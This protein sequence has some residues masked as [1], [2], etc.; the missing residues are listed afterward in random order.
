MEWK[1]EYW[2]VV[3]CIFVGAGYQFTNATKEDR[4]TLFQ[5]VYSQLAATVLVTLL[6]VGVGMILLELHLV[7]A[8]LWGLLLG[9]VGEKGLRLWMIDMN[10]ANS[11]LKF[12]KKLKRAYD[13]VE[14]EEHEH[15]TD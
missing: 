5:R 15:G 4:Y 9:V 12:V 1:I 7:W 6:C 2:L 11:L 10:K 14:K 3:F 8:C 13:L